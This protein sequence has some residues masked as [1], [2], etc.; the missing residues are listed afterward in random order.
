[1]SVAKTNDTKKYVLRVIRKFLIGSDN[2]PAVKLLKL[3]ASI[4]D[5]LGVDSIGR[6]EILRL[7]EKEFS[8]T[9]SDQRLLEAESVEDIVSIVNAA[10][11][12][13]E[14]EKKK[15]FF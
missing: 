5:D 11:H 6:A 14:S 13:K 9:I 4:E 1:M 15:P 2:R 10:K 3:D 7:L 12:I 8:I